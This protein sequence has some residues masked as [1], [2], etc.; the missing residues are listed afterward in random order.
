MEFERFVSVGFGRDRG[1]QESD[2]QVRTP[3]FGS[4]QIWRTN[5]PTI[6]ANKSSGSMTFFFLCIG[7]EAPGESDA[8]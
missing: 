4:T 3:I 5:H 7:D 2:I 8:A 1:S 6:N